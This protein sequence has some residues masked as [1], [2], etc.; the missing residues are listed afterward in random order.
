MTH[1]GAQHFLAGG[2]SLRA[3]HV[4]LLQAMDGDCSASWLMFPDLLKLVPH[5][6]VIERPFEDASDSYARA[7]GTESPGDVTG[8]LAAAMGRLQHHAALVVPYEAM[9]EMTSVKRICDF[10][11]VPFDLER[12]ALLRH[13]RVTQDVARV[14]AEVRTD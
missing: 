9:F 12:Y 7:V 14:A 5:V 2:R 10:I 1:E 6:V 13:L 8:P 4:A 3:A 11:E